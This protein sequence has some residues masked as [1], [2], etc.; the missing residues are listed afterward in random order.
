MSEARL[1]TM[2]MVGTRTRKMQMNTSRK[3][4][5]KTMPRMMLL[6]KEKK[7]EGV[8][9]RART[10]KRTKMQSLKRPPRPRKAPP[11]LR[12]R[13]TMAMEVTVTAAR[14][15]LHHLTK[16]PPAVAVARWIIPAAATTMPPL[17][18]PFS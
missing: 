6:A 14:R 13:L 12:R 11:R 1:M 3:A 9:S 17:L 18:L 8:K 10:T 16:L 4:L 2:T 5:T 7:E 15:K